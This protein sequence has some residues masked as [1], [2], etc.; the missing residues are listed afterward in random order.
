MQKNHTKLSK[1][2]LFTIL[3]GIY[4]ASLIISN[5]LAFKTFTIGGWLILPTAVIVFPIVYIVNDVMSEI[6]GF[7]KTRLVIFTAFSM[8]IIA[9]VAYNL[10]IILPAPVFFTG[11]EAFQTVL[12]TTFRILIASLAAYLVGS[13]SN[14]LVMNKMKQANE[15]RL[16]WRC[17]LSTL[18]GEGLDALIFITLAFI[19]TMPII[20]LIIMIVGQAIFKTL[21]ELVVYPITR[22]VILKARTLPEEN[23]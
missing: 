19:G 13:L 5:I 15:S 22:I 11:Q 9:V 2:L 16:M 18:V 14:S 12:S 17:I 4:C 20:D 10:A 21:Y 1:N 8:N 6:Y 3:S 23:V 7:K